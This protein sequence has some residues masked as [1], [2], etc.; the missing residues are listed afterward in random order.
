MV[1]FHTSFYLQRQRSQDFW[2]SLLDLGHDLLQQK[3]S[4]LSQSKKLL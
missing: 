3:M 4:S 1:L 2:Y